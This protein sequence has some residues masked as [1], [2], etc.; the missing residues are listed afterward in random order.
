MT[1]DASVIH[2]FANAIV[3]AASDYSSTNSGLAKTSGLDLDLDGLTNNS[4]RQ[5][6]DH[7]LG[8]NQPAKYAIYFCIEPGS[9]PTSN[10][11]C[12]FYWARMTDA[13]LGAPDGIT[14]TD[15]A[16]TGTTSDSI[17]DS[18]MQLEHIGAIVLTSDALP[19]YQSTAE[20][21]ASRLG[22]YGAPVVY[23]TSGQTLQTDGV[24]MYLALVPIIDQTA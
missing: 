12:E 22:R 24:E 16:Y 15:A 23:N 3:W 1:T 14:G 10:L 20:V 17:D 9:A 18:L 13:G 2:D 6:V 7:D 11:I 8:A 21:D 5:G 4:A 19:Q